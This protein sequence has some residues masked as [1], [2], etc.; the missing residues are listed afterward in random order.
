MMSSDDSDELGRS[1]VDNH[2]DG[3]LSPA[4]NGRERSAYSSVHNPT[5][6]SDEISSTS[7]SSARTCIRVLSATNIALI[8]SVVA[9]LVYTFQSSSSVASSSSSEAEDA[10][11]W[12]PLP[13]SDAVLTNIAFGSC[14]SQRMPQP[15]WDTLMK[16]QPDLVLLMG[17]N[18]YGDCEEESCQILQDAYYNMTQHPSVQGAARTFPV[19]ATLDDHDYGL[20][21]CHANNT[22]KEIARLLFADFFQLDNLPDDGVYQAAAWGPPGKRLQVILLDTRYS[23]SPFNATGIETSPYRPRNNDTEQQM[24]SSKQ[25]DWLEERLAESADLRLIIS[26]IQVLNDVTGAECWRH[27]PLER[28]RLYDIIQDR[29]DV[30]LLSGDR[31]VGGFYEVQGTQL[32]EVTASSWTHSVPLE[33]E[34]CTVINATLCDEED[35]RRIGSLVRENQYGTIQIDWENRQYTLAL[36]RADSSYGVTYLKAEHRPGKTSDAGEVLESRTYS[37]A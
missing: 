5:H 11:E 17:D 3:P 21:D 4:G 28:A 8:L 13:D 35:S 19:M 2:V 36:R 37:F 6:L 18:V 34:N 12:L 1:D 22:Y 27:L 20:N 10:L 24:L 31:H 14:S 30:V 23:R 7:P 32:K 33:A 16:T 15:Y 25:W 29:T 26:S 9:L